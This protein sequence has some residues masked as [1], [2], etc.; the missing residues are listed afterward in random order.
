MTE[1]DA[2]IDGFWPYRHDGTNYRAIPDKPADRAAVLAEIRR[3]AGH[4]DEIGDEGK[5]VL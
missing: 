5:D 4:E 1:N 3:M 2:F